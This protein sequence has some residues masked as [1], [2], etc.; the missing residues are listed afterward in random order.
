MK[1]DLVRTIAAMNAPPPPPP[2]PKKSSRKALI[3]LIVIVIVVVAAAV[4]AY[5]VLNNGSNTN[6]NSTPTPTPS[7][8]AT[9]T[10]SST[11][12]STS[13]QNG[14]G[15]ASSL[16]FSIDVTSG[17]V[18]QFTYTYMAKNVGTNNLM[19]RIETTD[20]SGTNNII[21]VN[22][23]LQKSWMYDGTEWTDISSMY[24]TQYNTWDASFIGYRNSL[25][26]WAGAG[27]WTYTAPN[28]D[29][30][31]YYDISVNPNLSDSLFQH[32]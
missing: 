4:G 8:G 26:D 19:L 2:P 16:Q 5:A 25:A 20:A 11:A 14:V 21:I 7:S 27:G 18:K 22:G 1:K 32:S 17:G 15:T 31:R 30:V 13:Q 29:S 9:S 24:N 23:V 28:G 12:T 10:P 3:A 6:N